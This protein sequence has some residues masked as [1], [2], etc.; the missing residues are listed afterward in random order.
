MDHELSLPQA[1]G[2]RAPVGSGKPRNV[3]KHRRAGIMRAIQCAIHF[4]IQITIQITMQITIES[5]I[6]STLEST[7]AS[8][9]GVARRRKIA[10]S[11]ACHGRRRMSW[12]VASND[13]YPF[14]H[15]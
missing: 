13:Y 9:A 14:F 6:E 1:T 11:A 8:R 15:A 4:A 10:R 12:C 7:K 3:R 5:V 2:R